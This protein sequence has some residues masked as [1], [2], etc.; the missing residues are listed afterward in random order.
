[1]LV[2]LNEGHWVLFAM[3]LAAII[4]SL[5]FHEFGHAWTAWCFGDD[6]A[7]RAGRLTLN[8]LAHIDPLGLLMVVF[9]GFG[10]A[11]PVPTNPS[12]FRSRYADLLVSAAGPA[13]NLL[14]AVVTINSYVLAIQF[15]WLS[16]DQ[17][18]PQTFCYLLT[19]INLLLMLFNLLPVGALDGHYILPYFLPRRWA[20][21][22][23]YYNSRY[24]NL[25]L[26]ALILLEVLPVGVPIFSTLMGVS[27]A[28]IGWI[29]I[30]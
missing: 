23:R 27:K 8:P 14:L 24:G 19:L 20:N 6:T 29:I 16:I 3:V 13:M 22:Y 9:V 1:M 10:Y 30:F 4:V 28:M 26:L 18:G 17:Q 7:Q 11:R 12:K 15:G 25:L 2:L 21:W 5:S